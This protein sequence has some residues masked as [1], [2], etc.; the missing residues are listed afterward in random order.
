MTICGTGAVVSSLESRPSSR[1]DAEVNLQRQEMG[2]IVEEGLGL[3]TRTNRSWTMPMKRPCARQRTSGYRGL[4]PGKFQPWLAANS[5]EA[6][7]PARGTRR[8][9]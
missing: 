3:A 2:R 4:H 9:S 6:F 5:G 7:F 8:Y 1:L